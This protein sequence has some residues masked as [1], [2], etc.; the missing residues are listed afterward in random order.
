ME[1]LRYN[2]IEFF[3]RE[4]N[5]DIDKSIIMVPELLLWMDATNQIILSSYEEYV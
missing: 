1:L 5:V 3:S 2:A 4:V